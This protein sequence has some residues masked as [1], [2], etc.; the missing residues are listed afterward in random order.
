MREAKRNLEASVNWSTG[1]L[2]CVGPMKRESSIASPDSFPPSP[3]TK[4]ITLDFYVCD[5]CTTMIDGEAF[6]LL[7]D[8]HDLGCNFLLDGRGKRKFGE[9]IAEASGIRV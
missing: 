2:M 4:L 6:K 1:T 3:K 7:G 5:N 8:F 9:R